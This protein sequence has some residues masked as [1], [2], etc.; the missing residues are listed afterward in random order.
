MSSAIEIQLI[1]VLVAIACALPGNFLI[2]RKLSMIAE[3][4]THTILLG[5]VVAFFMTG[6]L[7]S[8]YL[9]VGA[10]LTGVLTVWLIELLSKSKQLSC[11][12]SIGIVFP[13]LFSIAV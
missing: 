12:S 6:D 8:P 9:I 7:N 3:S 2:L 10:G 5:V 4:I 11:D 13:L 1:A